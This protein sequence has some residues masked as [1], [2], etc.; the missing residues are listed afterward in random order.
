V[1]SGADPLNLVGIL[2]PGPKV[3]AL[4]GN[5]VL[6]RDGVALAALIGGEVQYFEKL[7]QEK[8]WEVRNLL[9]RTPAPAGLAALM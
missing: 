1:V 2:V 3:A 8:A 6:Y 9:L 4:T 5:H 7:E